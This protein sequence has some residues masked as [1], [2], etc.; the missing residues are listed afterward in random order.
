MPPL[1]FDCTD[2]QAFALA[3]GLALAAY[4]ASLASEVTLEWSGLMVTGAAYAGV[5][6][7][8][9]YPAWTLY[10]WVFT[11]LIPF[12]NVAWRVAVG[13]AAAAATTCGLVALLASC[14]AKVL[15]A[16]SKHWS[17]FGDADQ[18]KLRVVSGTVAGLVLGFSTPY[19]QDAVTPETSAFGA[20]LFTGTL[21]LVTRAV[22][23]GERR[24]LLYW[25]FF[26]FGLLLTNNQE[27]LIVLPGFVGLVMLGKIELGRDLALITLP[28][29]VLV[30]SGNQYHVVP[31][32]AE[33]S[34]WN[35][36]LP[37]A[38]GATMLLAVLQV[39]RTRGF[40]SHWKAALGCAG[41][42]LLGLSLYLYVPIASMSTPPVDHGYP[43][44][45]DGFLHVLSRGQFERVHPTIGLGTLL[46]QCW[47]CLQVTGRHFGWLYLLIALLPIWGWR[48][49][50]ASGRYWWLGLLAVW[51][52][53]TPLM[54]GMLNPSV[55]RQSLMLA[56]SYLAPSRIVFAVWLG[57]GLALL[58]SLVAR[59]SPGARRN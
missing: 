49:I 35:W 17:K 38:F 2:K 13:S 1:P 39:T 34:P 10:S 37:A 12:S 56:E 46:E 21:C 33:G 43:R 57:L 16:G 41:S 9:G 11:K 42:L 8:P 55:D 44:T 4:L 59:S 54:I 19:W 29:A 14:G 30:T 32:P 48:S 23:G 47:A 50:S 27:L 31:W 22:L 25:A 28:L 24:R 53:A 58:G 5:P 20:L 6:M 3:A 7:P 18:A 36:P 40:G 45:L 52:C 51:I 26:L 15:F